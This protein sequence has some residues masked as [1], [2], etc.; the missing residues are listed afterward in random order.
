MVWTAS[1]CPSSAWKNKVTPDGTRNHAEPSASIGTVPEYA[2][3]RVIGGEAHLGE[4]HGRMGLGGNGYKAQAFDVPALHPAQPAIDVCE[5]ET[6]FL[7]AV[8]FDLGGRHR[9]ELLRAH[10]IGYMVE[11]LGR[12]RGSSWPSAS[13]QQIPI[14]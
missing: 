11:M 13:N 14:L 10:R 7:R 6:S 3:A 5:Q 2:L 12:D 8:R 4:V 9:W 1:P